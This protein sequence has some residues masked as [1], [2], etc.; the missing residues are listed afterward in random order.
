MHQIVEF[1]IRLSYAIHSVESVRSVGRSG[2]RMAKGRYSGGDMVVGDSGRR[3]DRDCH[4]RRA[5]EDFHDGGLLPRVRRL[6]AG[7]Q[8]RQRCGVRDGGGG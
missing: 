3:V 6:V 4:R 2:S 7:S 5:C 8:A 1:S